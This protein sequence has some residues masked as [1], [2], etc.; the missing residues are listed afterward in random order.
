MDAKYHNYAPDQMTMDAWYYDLIE[1]AL[2][3]YLCTLGTALEAEEDE[4]IDSSCILGSYILHSDSSSRDCV[5]EQPIGR[6]FWSRFVKDPVWDQLTQELRETKDC[7]F[8][9]ICFTPLSDGAP[10]AAFRGLMQM[11]MEHFLGKIHPEKMYRE[12]C[13]ICGSEEIDLNKL[14][15]FGNKMKYHIVCSRCKEF[16]VENH[17]YNSGSI[18]GGRELGKHLHNYYRVQPGSIWNVVCP[19]CGS[20]LGRV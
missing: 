19:E 2:Q 9:S 8:G 15:T 3:K 4:M 6:Y 20:K 10:D 1:V 13:W 5:G 12:K 17:C 18:C 11:I 7:R 14:P 16:W